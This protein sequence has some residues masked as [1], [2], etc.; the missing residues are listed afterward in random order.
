MDSSGYQV[1][2]IVMLDTLNASSGISG[3]EML[4]VSY[5]LRFRLLSLFSGKLASI[6]GFGTLCNRFCY[7]NLEL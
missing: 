1:F 3:F 4:Y 5:T 7:S 2:Y 6:W